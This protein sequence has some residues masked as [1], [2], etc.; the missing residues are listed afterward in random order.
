MSRLQRLLLVPCLAPIVLVLV[1]S[2]VQQRRPLA[3]N[4][5]I[6]TTPALPLGA[7]TAMATVAGAGVSAVGAL[8]LRPGT[9]PLRRTQ[10]QRVAAVD[11]S[12]PRM[13]DERAWEAPP[14]PVMP[15]RDIRDPAPT[16]SV[17]YRVV[18][19]PTAALRARVARTEPR[20]ATRKPKTSPIGDLGVKGIWYVS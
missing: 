3:L 11:P 13:Q 1:I 5:L 8:L 19:R 12:E 15:E 2:A 14:S 20:A 9:K 10:R 6:W 18:Q 16:V 7:W 17:A 4:V